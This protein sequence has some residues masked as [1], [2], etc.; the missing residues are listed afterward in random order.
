[1]AK[2]KKHPHDE[3]QE[4]K[5][6]MR[7]LITRFGSWQP[8]KRLPAR[9]EKGRFV[10]RTSESMRGGVARSRERAT[11]SSLGWH[12]SRLSQSTGQPDS[13]PSA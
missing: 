10:G 3:Q 9:D 8:M 13:G 11:A 6:Q 2:A 5:P 12:A 4:L 7:D 1:M